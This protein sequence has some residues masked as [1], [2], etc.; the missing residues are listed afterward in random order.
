MVHP[1]LAGLHGG[2]A[3]IALAGYCEFGG[4]R[5]SANR[6]TRPEPI[7]WRARGSRQEAN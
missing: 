7:G 4:G 2:A 6:V 1:F 5:L 3:A